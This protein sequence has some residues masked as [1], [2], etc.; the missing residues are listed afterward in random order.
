ML[1]PDPSLELESKH[2]PVVNSR[3]KPIRASRRKLEKKM[4]SNRFECLESL[5]FILN[6]KGIISRMVHPVKLKTECCVFGF[7]PLK[8][9]LSSSHF[10]QLVLGLQCRWTKFLVI[11]E[12]APVPSLVWGKLFLVSFIFL[13][14]KDL[15][16]L[17]LGVG[18]RLEVA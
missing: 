2:C 18:W 9:I 5:S 14:V 12:L 3:S 16:Q 13:Q 11:C 4:Q 1:P 7:F 6:E 17:T 15:C 10:S 8:K